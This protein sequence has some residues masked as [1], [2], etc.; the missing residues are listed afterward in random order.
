MNFL[1]SS[2]LENLADFG[3][4]QA[5]LT[6]QEGEGDAAIDMLPLAATGVHIGV[7]SVADNF[8]EALD[9]VGVFG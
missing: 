6:E 4:A 3:A 5:L 9:L 7:E 1:R 8:C 2:R